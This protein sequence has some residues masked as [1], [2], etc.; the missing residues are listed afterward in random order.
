MARKKDK[1]ARHKPSAPSLGEVPLEALEEEL[2]RLE[3]KADYSAMLDAAKVLYKRRP[4]AASGARLADAYQGR[5]GQLRD[6]GL[7]REAAALL[8]LRDRYRLVERSAE[9]RKE[10]FRLLLRAGQP[11]DAVKELRGWPGTREDADLLCADLVVVYPQASRFVDPETGGRLA[12]GLRAVQEA[13]A[14]YDRDDD[15]GA[16]E[17][18]KAVGVK[19]P[20]RHWRLFLRGAVAF[21]RRD[22]DNAAR[23][24]SAIPRETAPGQLAADFLRA[25]PGGTSSSLPSPATRPEPPS[26]ASRRDALAATAG[27][28]DFGVVLASAQA[29][30]AAAPDEPRVHRLVALYLWHLFL[31]HRG[32]DPSP[33][34]GTLRRFFSGKVVDD[35]GFG[36]TKAL[37]LEGMGDWEWAAARW[38]QFAEDLQKGRVR[39]PP[40]TTPEHARARVH[41]RAA[42]AL[43]RHAVE[44]RR[45]LYSPGDFFPSDIEKHCE[46][47]VALDP[48]RPH[49]YLSALALARDEGCDLKRAAHWAD[50]L[51]QRFPEHLE[52]LLAAADVALKRGVFQKATGL[53]RGAEAVE[54]RHPEV[55]RLR[56]HALLLS[57]RKR[58]A[59]GKLELARKDYEGALPF[60]E[61]RRAPMVELEL[62]VLAFAAG[63]H[64]D[65]ERLLDAAV[66]AL[67]G[68]AGAWFR[69]TIEGR[70]RGLERALLK[71]WSAR[72]D[73]WVKQPD[74]RAALELAAVYRDYEHQPRVG[75]TLDRPL[76]SK[77]LKKCARL[78]F[79]TDEAQTLCL[80][81]YDLGDKPALALLARQSTTA[82]P[83]DFHFPAFELLARPV[84]R[85]GDEEKLAYFR[86]KALE[87]GD[88]HFAQLL[89]RVSAHHARWRDDGRWDDEEQRDEFPVPAHPPPERVDEGARPL[90]KVGE[91]TGPGAPV[92]RPAPRRKKPPKRSHQLDLFGDAE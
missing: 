55:R 54:P 62:G 33:Q 52:G 26:L 57:A 48:D 80:L 64:A 23:A 10:R 31:A 56:G 5:M 6:K 81:L 72:L 28:R 89:R 47:A 83:G 15:D 18:L 71:Q 86:R 41:V 21:H 20:F 53:L 74:Q 8:P 61:A 1:R 14:A 46:A 36:R 9:E 40:A 59:E 58:A 2:A 66:A 88:E 77:T 70:L 50:R 39:L 38:S 29:L 32:R 27:D 65:G 17:I 79:T 19:S 63:R 76:V 87:G 75:Q 90:E 45:Q 49:A 68:G 69:A 7:Y 11:E 13:F 92:P 51:V 24:F 43:A 85:R 60:Q 3:E 37:A 84:L 82:H 78:P 12:K 91:E 4:D 35:A 16:L 30:A 44:V 22:D 34:W 25:L 42:K 73:E 67:G